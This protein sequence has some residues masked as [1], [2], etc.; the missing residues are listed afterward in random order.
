M[1]DGILVDRGDGLRV[2]MLLWKNLFFYNNSELIKKNVPSEYIQ[3]TFLFR[4]STHHIDFTYLGMRRK[5]KWDDSRLEELKLQDAPWVCLPGQISFST[6]T[7]CSTPN[8]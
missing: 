5:K 7:F 3:S 2:N 6:G 8:F 4:L 1:F